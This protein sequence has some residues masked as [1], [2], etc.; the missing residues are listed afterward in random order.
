VL[1]ATF[2]VA[3]QN[4]FAGFSEQ[5]EANGNLK[6]SISKTTMINREREFL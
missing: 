5:L 1:F 3:G 2:L 4:A 6:S